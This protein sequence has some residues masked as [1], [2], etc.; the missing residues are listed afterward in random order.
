[1]EIFLIL[2]LIL[3]VVIFY[4]NQNTK[5]H[6]L[7]TKLNKLE[8]Y[9]KSLKVN[10]DKNSVIQKTEIVEKWESSVKP[11]M[12]NPSEIKPEVIPTLVQPII[13]PIIKEVKI[14]ETKIN[15]I[16]PKL[17][18][19]EAPK[20]I[21]NPQP[22][23]HYV[24]Q[25]SWYEKSRKNNPDLEKFVGENLVSKIGIATLVIGIAFFVKF[26]IDKEW[27]N[28]IAR[29][30]IGIL[31]GVI[32]LG[33][34]H[35]L[36]AK[37][38]A[39]SSVLVAGGISIFYFTIGIAFHQYHIFNQTTAF[40]IM[41]F[42]TGF[43]VFTSVLYNR[44]ELAALSLIGGFATPF[45][46]STGE[47][48]Y[49]TLFVYVLILDIG[50]LVLAYLRKW[51][52]VNVLAYLFTIILYVG[53]LQG[54]VINE[55]NAPYKG[56][57]I[58]GSIFYFIFIVMN[59]I[60]N[61]KEKRKF[62]TLEL[63][64][65]ISNTF[66][67]YGTGMQILS[68]YHPELQGLYSILMG[69]FNLLCSWLLFKKFKADEKLVYLM[70]GL[71]LTFITLA[72]PIQLHGNYITLFWALESVLLIWLAQKSGIVLYRLV[73]VIITV[74]MG[75]SLMMDWENVYGYGTN[76]SIIFNKAFITGIVSSL[77]LLAV[78]LLLRKET[79]TVN[80]LGIRFNPK[81]YSSVLKIGFIG[82]LYLTGMIEL[83]Y[84]FGQY[85]EINTVLIIAVAYHMIF[86]SILNLLV[87]SYSPKSMIITNFILNYINCALFVLAFSLVP[88]SDFKENLWSNYPTQIGFI[89]HYI[90]IAAVIFMAY[91]MYKLRNQKDSPVMNMN[92]LNTILC[93]IAIIYVSS[94]E[95]VLHVSKLV[96]NPVVLPDGKYNYLKIEEF[97]ETKIHI[98]KVGFPILWGMLAFIFLFFGMKKQNKPF[99]IIA[100]VLLAITLVKL[101]TYDISNASEAGKIIAFIILG[102]VLLI[103]SFMYQKIKALLIDE[104]EGTKITEGIEETKE[105]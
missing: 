87:K 47:G 96:L 12:V 46:L 37:Y 6:L 102:L 91:R 14:D 73:S 57:F 21:I 82:I 20:Q 98:I 7:Q 40:V 61:I 30:G 67:F 45:M 27:I 88:I 29:V 24:P 80:Y 44:V 81:N 28:E 22:K 58:F 42:I 19:L 35:K 2:I 95:L 49:V 53:W 69:L 62:G 72:A 33:F 18:I 13:S 43:S 86:F 83:V 26:A 17:N 78:V 60:N 10:A 92:I 52:I 77:S 90:S 74:L 39:F 54:K 65:L 9:L 105:T 5:L 23:K 66:I 36:H 85:L 8:D 50:M 59:V 55:P 3:L 34:A 1:M 99:R 104:K 84:Q 101:F 100:L 71:T 48:N 75:I 41:L 89:T 11:I 31:C 51:N 76:A 4:T 56:A 16:S 79:D 70:I 32:V 64:I 97:N 38:K 15:D 103:I 94:A 63:S 93:A 68:C 25:E